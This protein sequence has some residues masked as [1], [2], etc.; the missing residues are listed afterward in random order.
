[1]GNHAASSDWEH[2]Q[3]HTN[4]THFVNILWKK[5][6][7]INVNRQF[8]HEEMY[9]HAYFTYNKEDAIM[10]NTITV[11]DNVHIKFYEVCYYFAILNQLKIAYTLSLW[12]L[13]SM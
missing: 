11:Y 5:G 6:Y 3:T 12:K 7:V 10:K 8:T 13:Y 9:A 4:K 2:R 1:M